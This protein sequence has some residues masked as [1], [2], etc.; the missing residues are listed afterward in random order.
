MDRAIEFI[1]IM[2]E[3]VLPAVAGIA[4]IGIFLWVGIKTVME[5]NEG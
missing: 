1:G 5:Y 2:I 3:V 4:F